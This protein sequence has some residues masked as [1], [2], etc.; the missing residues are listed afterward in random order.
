[1][2]T[3]MYINSHWIKVIFAQIEAKIVIASLFKNFKF[4]L[5]NTSEEIRY[6]NIGSIA[7]I[8]NDLNCHVNIL[9]NWKSLFIMIINLL[10]VA[11]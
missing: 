7:G 1:M 5:T 6:V 3:C 11:L 4:Q 9:V 8:A 10:L 2:N